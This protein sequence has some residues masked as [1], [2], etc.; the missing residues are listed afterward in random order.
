VAITRDEIRRY[1]A[2]GEEDSFHPGWMQDIF[3]SP[4]VRRETLRGAL[5]DEVRRRAGRATTPPAP[6]GGDLAAF[7]RAKLAPMVNGLFPQRERE[8]VLAALE[9]SVVFLTPD[10]IADV[11]RREPWHGTAWD[12]ANLYLLSVGAEPLAADA[13]RI[14]GLSQ[15]LTCYVSAS[16]FAEPDPFA[17][18]VVHEAAHVFHNCKRRTLGLPATRRKVWLLDIA[19]RQRETFAYAC[20]A[21]GRLLE[22]GRTPADRQRL[23]RDVEEDPPVAGGR[24]DVDIYLAAL[25]EAVAARNGWK[26]LLRAC[27]PPK[28]Q[29]S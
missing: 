13:P 12:L 19:F 2:T 18:F 1:L 22:L 7:A 4:G 11:L 3:R 5:V 25:R 28:G 6:A 15:G 17:D 16:Y 8:T 23:L 29:P 27:A 21:Y 14:V 10:T 9:R 24:V 26:R 20:E